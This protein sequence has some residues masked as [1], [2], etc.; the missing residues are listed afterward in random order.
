M[1]R[2]VLR[3]Y[4][5][6]H[7]SK[8]ALTFK[9][10]EELWKKYQGCIDV[11]FPSPKTANEWLLKPGGWVGCIPLTEDIILEVQPKVPLNKLFALLEIAYG[12]SGLRV[13]MF[14]SVI[15]IQRLDAFF[16]RIAKI[17]ASQVLLRSKRGFHR[18]YIDKKDALLFIKGR[19]CIKDL[20]KRKWDPRTVC[21]YQE[22]TS[23]IED[24]RLLAWTL[25]RILR[26][27]FCS[28]YNLPLIRRAYRTALAASSLQEYSGNDCLGRVYS[29]LN[30]DY[31]RYHNLCR[32]FLDSI[33]PN[34]A[35]GSGA[36][37]PFLI[38]M[39]YVFEMCVANWIGNFISDSPDYADLEIV[40]HYKDTRRGVMGSYSYDID[41]LLRRNGSPYMVIDTKYKNPEG[42]DSG[43]VQQV[44]T[45]ADLTGSDEAV[46]VY[47]AD[48]R[49]PLDIHIGD[50]R[51]RSMT[52][53][54]AKQLDISGRELI[55]R[56]LSR[57]VFV[58]SSALQA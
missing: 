30:D 31:Q 16:D 13:K 21:K 52:F 18:S 53:D 37:V 58:K 19:M 33:G 56:L 7:L 4:E 11:Q 22:H 3:E 8:D 38:E 47:P 42:P 41:I 35:E 23:D 44:V 55:S 34:L 14:D 17:L 50:V 6:K 36:M 1:K 29:R 49:S 26:S 46:L 10:G 39:P 54:L 27:G 45:Y 43:D 32:F 5:E 40:T 25:Y 24:N 15:D 2:Y 20:I 28:S 12:L 51:V 9:T 57:D 48:L